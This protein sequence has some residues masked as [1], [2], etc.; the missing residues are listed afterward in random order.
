MC[1]KEDLWGTPRSRSPRTKEF[2]A[3][4]LL[5]KILK[6]GFPKIEIHCVGAVVQIICALKCFLTRL[7]F[8]SLGQGWGQVLSVWRWNGIRPLGVCRATVFISVSVFGA[9]WRRRDELSVRRR[10]NGWRPRGLGGQLAHL[11]TSCTSKQNPAM[12]PSPTRRADNMRS[13]ESC[14]SFKHHAHIA[15]L[16]GVYSTKLHNKH[17]IRKH[18]SLHIV[19]SGLKPPIWQVQRWQSTVVFGKFNLHYYLFGLPFR[20][21]FLTLVY[22]W[23]WSKSW[24][25]VGRGHGTPWS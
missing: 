4:T 8:E 11:D 17:Y 12:Q 14:D 1:V 18:H 13:T 20:A 5:L 23:E 10:W 9:V 22:T 16:L 2:I 21:V 6:D 24:R 19:V 25:S 7:T 15:Q 3:Q